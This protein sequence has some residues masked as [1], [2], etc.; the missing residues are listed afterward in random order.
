MKRRSARDG[1]HGQWVQA[2]PGSWK[3]NENINRRC[4]CAGS[5]LRDGCWFKGGQRV[6]TEPPGPSRTETPGM[7]GH[8]YVGWWLLLQPHWDLQRK[9][10]Y[11][12]HRSKY[13]V[14]LGN[15]D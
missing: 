2:T 3:E 4:Y 15:A 11:T 7:P 9:E 8:W 1:S 12:P 6:H 13:V 10:T 5:K 14:R